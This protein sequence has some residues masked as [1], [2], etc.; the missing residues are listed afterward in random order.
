MSTLLKRVL[1]RMGDHSAVGPDGMLVPHLKLLEMPRTVALE[2]S[3]L[4]ALQRF[5][6]FMVEGSLSK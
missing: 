4:A 1:R 5:A 6:C 3:G 2:K